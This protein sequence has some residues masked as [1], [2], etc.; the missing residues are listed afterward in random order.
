ML[1]S[2][3]PAAPTVSPMTAELTRIRHPAVSAG[4]AIR[5]LHTA[6][7]AVDSAMVSTYSSG[8]RCGAGIDT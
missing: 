7:H 3:V 6:S 8:L 5:K 1:G 4:E 2:E